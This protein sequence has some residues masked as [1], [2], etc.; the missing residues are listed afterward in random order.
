MSIWN[1]KQPEDQQP[2]E[3]ATP[4]ADVEARAVADRLPNMLGQPVIIDNRPGA[5][6]MI[7]MNM[8]QDDIVD[9]FGIQSEPGQCG[10]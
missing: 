6:G 9:S 1:V 4:A 3:P 5:T 10:E 2:V 8:G 7:E